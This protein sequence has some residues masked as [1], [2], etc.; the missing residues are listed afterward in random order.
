LYGQWLA[1]NE[2]A[3]PRRNR[4][5]VVLSTEDINALKEWRSSSNKRRWERAVALLDLY[6][7]CA[8]A[9]LCRKLD[10]SPQTI[11]RWHRFFVTAG[12]P[13][14]APLR[15][16]VRQVSRRPR[17]DPRRPERGHGGHDLHDRRDR[18]GSYTRMGRQMAGMDWPSS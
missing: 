9:S 14:V 15:P 18:N 3:R 10:R 16:L 2:L 8:M 1:S 5:P 11:K 17:Q 4:W 6:K 13:G 12:L 7:G